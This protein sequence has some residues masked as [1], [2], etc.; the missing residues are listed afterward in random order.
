M[1]PTRRRGVAGGDD[2]RGPVSD[3]PTE[4]RI[5]CGA[6]QCTWHDDGEANYPPADTHPGIAKNCRLQLIVGACDAHCQRIEEEW[7]R[8]ADRTTSGAGTDQERGADKLHQD[9]RDPARTQ[10]TSGLAPSPRPR[11]ALSTVGRVRYGNG[12]T[13]PKP[14]DISATDR[15]DG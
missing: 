6:C 13:D 4:W 12:G 10:R 3:P 11:G 9:W 2:T 14:L 5:W 8:I 15:E 1:M 7:V